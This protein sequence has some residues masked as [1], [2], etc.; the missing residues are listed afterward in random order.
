MSSTTPAEVR[1][2]LIDAL[3]LDLVGPTPDD[4]VHADEIIPQPLSKW[5]LTGFLVPYDAPMEVRS[6]DTGND[7][8]DAVGKVGAGDDETTPD[9]AP[10]RK[11][12]FP[13]SMGV[14]LLLATHTTSLHVTATWGDYTRYAADKSEEESQSTLRV[15]T[16][17]RSPYQA[18]L[19]IPIQVSDTPVEFDIPESKGLKLIVSVRPVSSEALVP[20]GTRSVSIFLVN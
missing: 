16:W 4:L 3:Q 20:A 12:F 1:T 5:Y 7:E 19:T 13:S 18:E 6:D 2:H 14:S 11:G 9:R 15:G 10:A 8:M 17:Q